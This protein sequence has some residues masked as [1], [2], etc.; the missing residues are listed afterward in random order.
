[1]ETEF[2]PHCDEVKFVHICWQGTAQHFRDWEFRTQIRVMQQKEKQRRGVLKDMRADMCRCLR[3]GA[4][5][6]A[7]I[8]RGKFS[9]RGDGTSSA[10]HRPRVRQS[11]PVRSLLA[12][13][14]LADKRGQSQ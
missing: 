5:S 6:F 12:R 3:E 11:P 13:Q 1:M 14:A 7:R 4:I 8:C 9:L 2:R 10:D